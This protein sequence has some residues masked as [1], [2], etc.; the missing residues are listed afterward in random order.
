MAAAAPAKIVLKK[1]PAKRKPKV[2]PPPP[3]KAE[4][5][6]GNA[7]QVDEITKELRE[8]ELELPKVP[9][10][11][12]IARDLLMDGIDD[13]KEQ[14]EDLAQQLEDINASTEVEPIVA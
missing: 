12:P 10:D 8:F 3:T 4:L 14:L 2:K 7:E 1:A 5:L 13:A 9:M 11:C 6:K